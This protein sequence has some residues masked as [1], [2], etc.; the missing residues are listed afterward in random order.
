MLQRIL[1]LPRRLRESYDL[2][3]LRVGVCG[4]S[5]L[6][7]DVALSFMDRFGDIVYNFYG[8]TEAAF[9][10]VAGPNDLRVAPGT[11]GRAI[12]G[13]TLRIADENGRRVKPG[14]VGRILVG[15]G[16]RMDEYTWG[17]E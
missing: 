1:A 9:A 3:S 2:S 12:P 7:A 5:A 6:P 11:A 8:S 14:V 16:L 10:T 17:D 13:V 15:S 4:G